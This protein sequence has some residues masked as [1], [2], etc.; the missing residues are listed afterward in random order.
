M[1]VEGLIVAGVPA[2][3]GAA[4]IWFATLMAARRLRPNH[5]VGIRTSKTMRSDEAWYTAHVAAAPWFRV[6]GILL[7][8]GSAISLAVAGR[9]EPS[10]LAAAIH[11]AA[12]LLPVVV[13]LV[14]SL[15]GLRAA[16]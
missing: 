9:D 11:Q 1:T 5:V 4:L 13:L 8:V 10:L 15:V 6:G 3:L 7:L 16:K 12:L 2:L 14:G